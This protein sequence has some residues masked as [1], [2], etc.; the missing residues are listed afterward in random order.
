MKDEQVMF[1]LYASID[2]LI[3]FDGYDFLDVDEI[4]KSP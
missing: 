3:D 2:D 1:W 4:E